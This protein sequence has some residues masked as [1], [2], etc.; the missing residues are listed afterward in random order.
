LK[1]WKPQGVWRPDGV[2]GDRIHVEKELG[3]KRCG[4]WSSGIVDVVGWGIE[5]GV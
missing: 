5:Y 4:M 3:E 1:D 2:E